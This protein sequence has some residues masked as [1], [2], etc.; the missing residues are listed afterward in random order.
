LFFQYWLFMYFFIHPHL[1]SVLNVLSSPRSG[2]TS[3]RG[4]VSLGP[5]SLDAAPGQA[6]KAWIELDT[7]PVPPQFFGHQP[8]CAR[9]EE[10]VED[11]PRLV[12]G[13]APAGG[14]EFTVHGQVT[15]LRMNVAAPRPPTG[16]TYLLGAAGQQD[17][18]N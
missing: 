15:D 4:A 12:A 13:S 14:Q 16:S 11:D 9:P 18:S 3:D 17:P 6:G 2:C 5:G 10:G 8:D 7:Q 1:L